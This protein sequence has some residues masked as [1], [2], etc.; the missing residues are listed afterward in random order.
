L[1]KRYGPLAFLFVAPEEPIFGNHHEE[2]TRKAADLL[3]SCFNKLI[4]R[5]I[6]RGL[7]QLR[8]HWHV[9]STLRLNKKANYDHANDRERRQRHAEAGSD[10][11]PRRSDA[12]EVDH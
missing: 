3:A 5:K 9:R 8:S 6:E 2:V 1:E 11:P 4:T 7:A 10:S 12:R